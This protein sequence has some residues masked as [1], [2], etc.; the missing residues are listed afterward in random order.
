MNKEQ[1]AMSNEI[2]TPTSGPHSSLLTISGVDIQ[3]GIYMTGG[4]MAV[5]REVLNC[6]CEEV[7]QRLPEL[8]KATDTDTITALRGFIIHVTAIKGAAGSIGAS[9]TS[10]Q[11]EKLVIAAMK[12]DI[13][14]IRKKLPVF[15][16]Y[17]SELMNNIATFLSTER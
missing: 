6:F 1:V 16:E 13:D 11:A 14:F 4:T 7:G 3:T 5:Y 17:L 8:Q 15:T 2:N 12:A 9:E 10:A